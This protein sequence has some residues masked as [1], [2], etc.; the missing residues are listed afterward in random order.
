[1]EWGIF[2][3]FLVMVFGVHL[4]TSFVDLGIVYMVKFLVGIL[5][6]K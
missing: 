3:R 2:K 5:I 6:F 1:M 4:Q